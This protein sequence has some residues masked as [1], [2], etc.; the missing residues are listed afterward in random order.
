MFRIFYLNKNIWK[1]FSIS[2]LILISTSYSFSQKNSIEVFNRNEIWGSNMPNRTFLYTQYG[3][4]EKKFDLFI[5]PTIMFTNGSKATILDTDFYPKFT[6]GYGYFNLAYSNSTQFFPRIRAGGE[7]YK[8]IGK[9][10]E[11]SLG[12]RYINIVYPENYNIYSLTGT[13][14][15][16]FGDYFTYIRPTMSI[17]DDGVVWNGM[18]ALRRYFNKDYIELM[19][20][21][22][23]DTGIERNVSA[24]ENNFGLQTYMVRLKGNLNITE[25]TTISLGYDYS[26]IYIPAR[27]GYININSI[28]LSLKRKF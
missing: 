13:L 12:A 8:P 11:G 20:G 21:R 16:Y 22:G 6:K 17:I 5:R 18:W 28:D 1:I 2:V 27:D 15:K 4:H 3:R 19:M 10:F 25:L 23:V 7:I 14:G 24:I 9:T 26:G